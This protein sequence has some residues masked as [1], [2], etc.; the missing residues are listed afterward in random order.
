[1]RLGLS[2]PALRARMWDGQYRSQRY[3]VEALRGQNPDPGYEFEL[4]VATGACLA[5]ASV[6]IMRWAEG[7]G[8][9][10]LPSLMATALRIVTAPG[11]TQQTTQDGSEQ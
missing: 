3:I 9:E 11:T 10:D 4:W 5:A 6:A 8:H 7:D 2:V 1:M